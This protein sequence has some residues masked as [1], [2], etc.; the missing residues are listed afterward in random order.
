MG[1][2]K[3]YF[4]HHLTLNAKVY[5]SVLIQGNSIFLGYNFKL[6][7][8]LLI[9]VKQKLVELCGFVSFSIILVLIT[10]KLVCNLYQV[11][12][13]AKRKWVRRKTWHKWSKIIIKI[14]S[15]I[16]LLSLC[17]LSAIKTNMWRNNKHNIIKYL[18]PNRQNLKWIPISRQI[19][20]FYL[21]T[22]HFI[23]Y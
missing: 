6:N 10:L 14:S 19:Q 18:H 2:Q 21:W 17:L 3:W 4:F 8:D 7:F 20:N 23:L 5:K 12:F 1:I 15:K 9:Q 16:F 13:N 22:I 11:N